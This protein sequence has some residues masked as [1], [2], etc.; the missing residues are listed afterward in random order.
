[1]TMTLSSYVK[2]IEIKNIEFYIMQ[3]ALGF[4][5]IFFSFFFFFSNVT[6][7]LIQNG[8][9][10]FVSSRCELTPLLAKNKNPNRFNEFELIKMNRSVSCRSVFPPCSVSANVTPTT[11]PC[12]VD[13]ALFFTE[14]FR[15]TTV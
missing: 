1:M 2:N 6:F 12:T 4:F 13:V 15:P 7:Q 14:F 3:M 8:A 9:L 5:F 10:I 11:D